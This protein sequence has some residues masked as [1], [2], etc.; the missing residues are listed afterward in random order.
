MEFITLAAV[1]TTGAACLPVL[2]RLLPV[3]VVFATCIA[4]AL[5]G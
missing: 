4:I 1:A 3:V 2:L 5:S